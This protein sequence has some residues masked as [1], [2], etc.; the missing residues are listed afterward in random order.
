MSILSTTKGD[1][2]LHPLALA[3]ILAGTRPTAPPVV[4]TTPALPPGYDMPNSGSFV[5]EESRPFWPSIAQQAYAWRHT[6]EN[7]SGKDIA[8]ELP[9]GIAEATRWVLEQENP[10]RD[11]RTTAWGQLEVRT[12]AA[13]LSQADKVA[14]MH[15]V[16]LAEAAK[17]A[18]AARTADANREYRRVRTTCAV[19]GQVNPQTKRPRVDIGTGREELLRDQMCPPCARVYLAHLLDQARAEKVN[20]KTRAQLVAAFV[21]KA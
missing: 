20:G 12:K 9:T 4:D 16:H 19:C 14:Y 2:E 21:S 8:T 13:R 15:Q 7:D 5:P 3:G 10:H 18:K 11:P 17:K 6:F 1:D